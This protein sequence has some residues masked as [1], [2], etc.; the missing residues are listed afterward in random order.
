[1]A[2]STLA[3]L[4][5]RG[6]FGL[7]RPAITPRT[8]RK[9]RRTPPAAVAIEIFFVVQGGASHDRSVAST[10]ERGASA[11]A[12]RAGRTDLAGCTTGPSGDWRISGTASS[13]SSGATL[14]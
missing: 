8:T 13:G 11:L 1:A 4:A 6:T 14:G 5:A 9:P 3:A 2:S 7:P 12:R 10:P